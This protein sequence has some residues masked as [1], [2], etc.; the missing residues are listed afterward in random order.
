MENKL[1]S[2][3]I[4]AE[5]GFFKK[6]DINEGI[7][8]T[9]NMIHKPALLGILG[10]II[11]LNGFEKHGKMP[12]YYEKLKDIKLGIKP[13]G[14]EKGVFQKTIISYTN[15][16]G[17]A[18]EE[19]S[20]ILT[21]T[22]QT[23][24]KPSYKVY[25][26][27]NMND[28]LQQVLYHNIKEQKAEFLPYMGKN[29]YPLWW[30]KN[31]VYEHQ[32]EHLNEHIEVKIDTIFEKKEPIKN[33]IVK[34]LGRKALLEQRN[35]FYRFEKLPISYDQSLLQYKLTDF[36]YTNATLKIENL[37]DINGFYYL[38]DTNKIVYLF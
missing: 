17:L 18:T 28:N 2:F 7:Y 19:K 6:P 20:G 4:K 21:I 33:L 24:I 14:D 23:L 37:K 9:Y 35:L 38:K 11:G 22:E 31:D 30:S 12:E 3:T 10:A 15:T 36:A 1:I 16:T 5:K 27:I 25:I 13:I 8:L 29:D 34:S 32:F 26:L